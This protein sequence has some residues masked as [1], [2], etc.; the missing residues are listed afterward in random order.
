MLLLYPAVRSQKPQLIARF[1]SW[2]L[3]RCARGC[4]DP[5]VRVQKNSDA[6][7]HPWAGLTMLKTREE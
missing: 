6:C 7:H 2:L 1:G 3:I 4:E 5:V